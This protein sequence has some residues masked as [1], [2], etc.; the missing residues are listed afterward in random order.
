MENI[1]VAL[2]EERIQVTVG[3]AGPRPSIRA[4]YSAPVKQAGPEGWAP[5]LA[6]LWTAHGL[7]R[8]GVTLVLPDTAAAVRTISAPD[9]SEK[10]L[11]EL[12]G[13]EM[14]GR[15]QDPV[16]ADY[17]PLGRDSEGHLRLLC[18][19]CRREVLEGYL[20]LFREQ[21]IALAGVTVPLA[22]Y[23][24]LI[25]SMPEMAGQTCLW[26]CFE[27]ASVLSVLIEDGA[28]RWSSRSRIFSEPGTLDFG[29]EIAR[30]VSG[31]MQ[32][33][34]TGRTG[35]SI[36]TV[37]LAGGDKDLLE[38]CRPGI[39]GLGLS[40]APLPEQGPFRALPAGEALGDWLDCAGAM[41]R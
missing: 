12:V 30:N 28:Y 20:D 33:Q 34:T 14:Q 5:V 38:V 8:K 11:V 17:V 15:D 32:F 27:E 6:E 23:L 35:H 36:G 10:Q 19:S 26:L 2:R 13:H 16:V 31:T 40:V 21:G 9:M 7:P 18:A 29:T 39:E 4:A 1:V 41:I 22:G 25:R 24:K 37:Y 3:K